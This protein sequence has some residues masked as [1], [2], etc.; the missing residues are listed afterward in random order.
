[1]KDAHDRRDFQAF[2]K[3]ADDGTVLAVVEVAAGAPTPFD[4][5]Y[6]DV[7]ARQGVNRQTLTFD[8]KTVQAAKTD[9][10][11]RADAAVAVE[12]EAKNAIASR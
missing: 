9:Q 10:T 11:A 5:A 7:T 12:A 2:A 4:A 3:V 6:I 8:A 1:M